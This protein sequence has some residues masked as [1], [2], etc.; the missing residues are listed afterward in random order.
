MKY[1]TMTD[2]VFEQRPNRFLAHCKLQGETV[3]AHVKNTGRCRELLLPG[4][5]VWLQDH[6][7]EK[8][9]RKTEFSLIAVEKETEQGTLLINMDSQA[10]NQVAEEGLMSGSIQ[11]PLA[12]GE[13]ICSVRREVTFGSSRFD[14]QVCTNQR[15]WYVEV[16]GVTL[17][18][19]R[20]GIRTA[21]F[22]DAPTQRGVKHIH[23]LIAA[24]EAGYGAALLFL[25]QMTQVDQFRP[26]WQTHCDFGF[27][28]Q[29]AQ[30]AGVAVLAYDCRVTQASLTAAK[31]VKVNLSSCETALWFSADEKESLLALLDEEDGELLSTLHRGK[32]G[33]QSALVQALMKQAA[34]ELG[35]SAVKIT[36]N[37]KGAPITN[38]KEL[39]VSASHTEGCCAAAAALHPVGI[40]AEV[41][42]EAREK[43]I[44]RLFSK[45]EQAYLDAC[46]DRNLAFTRLWT[47]K[48]AYGK[49]RG[50]GLSVA[51]EV[52]FFEENG[53][54]ICT[55]RGL[56][57][58]TEQQNNKLISKVELGSD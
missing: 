12:E 8:K 44:A 14:L 6:R 42:G 52:E 57:I 49:M 34:K 58:S 56:K 25:I 47:L 4:V 5:K 17:E 55:D 43:V 11:L 37:E 7:Q 20:Q 9:Q 53:L 27:A 40:D 54:L 38:R 3:V 36:R 51:K 28:L 1:D 21:R 35:F 46:E 15:I 50:V 31:P 26:N 29:Q 32:A 13:E 16:K 39:F 41:I 2:A 19:S 45:R 18:E 10:P 33:E 22:P 23:E 48:E 24:K 30:K